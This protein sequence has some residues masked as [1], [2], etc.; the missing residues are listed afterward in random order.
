MLDT[1]WDVDRGHFPR[2]GLVDRRFNPRMAGHVRRN[3]YSVFDASPSGIVSG[4]MFPAFGGHVLA[5][6][7]SREDW[8]AI[9][10]KRPVTIESLPWLRARKPNARAGTCIDFVSGKIKPVTWTGAD[11]GGEPAARR[12]ETVACR[13]S[14]LFCLP[15]S[16]A[17]RSTPVDRVGE[18]E[19]HKE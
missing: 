11:R 8:F 10:P 2:T 5:L 9:L 19:T 16:G 1:F 6:E 12:R 7:G 3:L 14:K 17:I 15:S 18:R 4:R 13:A